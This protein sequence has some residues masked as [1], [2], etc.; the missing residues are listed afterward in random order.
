MIAWVSAA[1]FFIALIV[2]LWLLNSTRIEN[3]LAYGGPADDSVLKSPNT[4]LVV[5][6]NRVATDVPSIA[7]GLADAT[8]FSAL[9]QSTGVAA[10]LKGKGPYTIFVPTDRAMRQLP[11]GMLST[12]SATELKRFVQYHVVPTRSIDVNAVDTGFV[13]ALSGDTLNLS[14]QAGDQSSRVNNSVV[15]EGYTTKNGMVYLIN[16]ALLPPLKLNP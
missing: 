13:Q 2:T 7:L 11:A 9:L 8:R 10:Q 3:T 1:F 15:L 4:P 5:T 12:M 16:S 14:V 6:Q